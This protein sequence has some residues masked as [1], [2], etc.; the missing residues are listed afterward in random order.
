MSADVRGGASAPCPVADLDTE[1]VTVIMDKN[2]IFFVHNGESKTAEKT[3]EFTKEA[4]VPTA[5]APKKAAKKSS[6]CGGCGGTDS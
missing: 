3:V 2:N 4:P 6:C 1:N 5:H